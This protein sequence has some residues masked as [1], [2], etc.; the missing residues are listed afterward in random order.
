MAPQPRALRPPPTLFRS[1]QPTRLAPATLAQAY[2]LLL[3]DHRRP[4]P[5]PTPDDAN[6]P[7][8]ANRHSSAAAG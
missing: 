7:Q 5:R 8:P 2:Q 3:P 1:F 6:A 4:L